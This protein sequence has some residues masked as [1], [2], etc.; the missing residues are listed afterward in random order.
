MPDAGNP[1][2][3]LVD[4]LV[5]GAELVATMDG[6]RQELRGGWVAVTGGLVSA[7]GASTDPQPAARRRLSAAGCLVTPGLVN[8]H[9]GVNCGGVCSPSG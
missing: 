1:P 8:T 7:V 5:H 6:G 9:R 3:L 2:A 4:L